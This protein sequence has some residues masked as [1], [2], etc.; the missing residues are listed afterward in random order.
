MNGFRFNDKHLFQIQALQLLVNMGFECL[1]SAKALAA[2]QEFDL[3][4][5]QADALR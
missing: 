1:P 5:K 3:L 4:R 2:R